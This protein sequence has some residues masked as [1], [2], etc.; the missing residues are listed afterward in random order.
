[1]ISATPSLTFAFSFGC[2]LEAANGVINF[3]LSKSVLPVTLSITGDLFSGGG[4][5]GTTVI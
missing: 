1:M 3:C 4:K 2:T 5:T